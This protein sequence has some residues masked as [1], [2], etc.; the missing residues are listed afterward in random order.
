[1]LKRQEFHG[2]LSDELQ[3]EPTWL[4]DALTTWFWGTNIVSK[5]NRKKKKMSA[6]L[7]SWDLSRQKQKPTP[8]FCMKQEVLF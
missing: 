8:R 2:L 7:F 3:Q 5:E 4:Q 6:L 1:M